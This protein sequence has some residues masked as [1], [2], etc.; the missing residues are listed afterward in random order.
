M[1]PA[2][3]L[4]SE[5]SG[6]RLSKELHETTQAS[7]THTCNCGPQHHQHPPLNI[8]YPYLHHNRNSK[9]SKRHSTSRPGEYAWYSLSPLHCGCRFYHTCTYWTQASFQVATM[10]TFPWWMEICHSSECGM[11]TLSTIT[12]SIWTGTASFLREDLPFSYVWSDIP[13]CMDTHLCYGTFGRDPP[14][15][16][17]S[18]LRVTNK[19]VSLYSSAALERRWNN[20][21]HCIS[22]R[23]AYFLLPGEATSPSQLLCTPSTAS[24]WGS[25]GRLYHHCNPAHSHDSGKDVPWYELEVVASL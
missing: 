1:R 3:T 15:L 14:H 7:F 20:Q 8:R 6:F 2:L 16:L 24:S 23:H 11:V 10:A 18:P 5:G 17:S 13:Y 25:G 4:H 21:H 12:V 9:G 19:R 22:H